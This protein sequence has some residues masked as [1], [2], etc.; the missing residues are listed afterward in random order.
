MKDYKSIY[1]DIWN[2]HKKYNFSFDFSEEHW[3]NLLHETDAISKKY[4][5]DSF[6]NSLIMAV[7]SEFEN[8]QKKN[9]V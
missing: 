9:G 2:L 5:N 8:E 1:T 4:N 3:E 7:I 6:V